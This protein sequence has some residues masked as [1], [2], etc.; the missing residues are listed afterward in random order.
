MMSFRNVQFNLFHM[1]LLNFS[2]DVLLMDTSSPVR[3]SSVLST[4][5]TTSSIDV[6]AFGKV[7]ALLGIVC[8][9]TTAVSNTHRK[10]IKVYLI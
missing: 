4:R 7:W 5:S 9:N 10:Q 8:L 1:V 3:R 6:M 2:R